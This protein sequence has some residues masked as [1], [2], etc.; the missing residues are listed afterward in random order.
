[1][2]KKVEFYQID[3]LSFLESEVPKVEQIHK[4]WLGIKIFWAIII[5][6][7]IATTLTKTIL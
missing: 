1:L 2:Q 5:V 7:G 3:R 4:N 6:A